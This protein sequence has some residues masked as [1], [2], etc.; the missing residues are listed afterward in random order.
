ME[1]CLP[2]EAAV[3]LKFH[4]EA[5]VWQRCEVVVVDSSVDESCRNAN[6]SDVI[7]NGEL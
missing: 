6:L 5:R 1:R 3:I 7:F 4:L 2:D